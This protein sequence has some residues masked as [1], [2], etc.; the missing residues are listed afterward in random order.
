M[1]ITIKQE[2]DESL[3]SSKVGGKSYGTIEGCQS[4]NAE[5]GATAPSGHFDN[6]KRRLQK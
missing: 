4:A 1:S 2:I 3:L 5:K 6:E